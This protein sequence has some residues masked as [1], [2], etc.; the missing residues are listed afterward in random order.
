MGAGDV[1]GK[2]TCGEAEFGG[3]GARQ[4][5]FTDQATGM[6]GFPAICA[7]ATGPTAAIRAGPRGPSGV[8]AA[9]RLASRIRF[10][11]RSPDRALRFELP[12]TVRTPRWF[13]VCA[14]MRPSGCGDCRAVIA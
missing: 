13:T 6:M 11:P 9:I 14:S 1:A 8:T 7:S 12:Q 10:M 4:N 2:D 5:L 3:I